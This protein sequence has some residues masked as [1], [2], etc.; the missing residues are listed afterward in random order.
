MVPTLAPDEL[1]LVDPDRMPSEGEVV[2]ARIEPEGLTV[3]K[4]VGAIGVDG[5]HLLISDNPGEGTDS[6]QWGPV[7][8]AAIVGTVTLN[9]SRPLVSLDPRRPGDGPSARWLRR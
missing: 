7:P 3:I 2:V 5:A 1:V 9:L 6:R 8:E 4:R